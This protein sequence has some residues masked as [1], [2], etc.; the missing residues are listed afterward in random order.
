MASVPRRS[1]SIPPVP[2][3]EPTPAVDQLAHQVAAAAS[4]GFS[5]GGD[6]ALVD[7]PGRFDLDVPVGGEQ[8]FESAALPVGEQIGSGVQGPPGGIQRSSMPIYPAHSQNCNG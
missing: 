1:R 8:G 2:I 3:P 7:A 5:V 4:V 6:H